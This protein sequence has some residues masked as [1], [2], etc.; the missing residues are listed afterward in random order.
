MLGTREQVLSTV[1]K[2]SDVDWLIGREFWEFISD[3]PT[4]IET[5]YEIA[6]E[7]SENF[8][9]ESGQTITE[10]LESKIRELTLEFERIYGTGGAVMWQNLLEKNS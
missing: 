8:R 3:E 10:L 9:N 7:V 1:R 4:C 6:A 5:I 2:Y